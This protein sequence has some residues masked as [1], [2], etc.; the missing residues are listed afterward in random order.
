MPNAIPTLTEDNLGPLKEDLE[1]YPDSIHYWSAKHINQFL[2]EF[3]ASC[4]LLL[5]LRGGGQ[6]IYQ[7]FW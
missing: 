3:I 2:Q 5:Q 1:P 6:E 4:D 7:L